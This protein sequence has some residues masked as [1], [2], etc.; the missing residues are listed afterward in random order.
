[1]RWHQ[2]SSAPGLHLRGLPLVRRNCSVGRPQGQAMRFEFGCPWCGLFFRSMWRK[3]L[4][5]RLRH[6][7]KAPEKVDLND[8]K[9]NP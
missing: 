8:N 2:V 6:R 9:E 3:R 4:H 5:D 7:S 1:V